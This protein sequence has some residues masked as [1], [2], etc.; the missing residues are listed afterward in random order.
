MENMEQHPEE[1]QKSPKPI[2]HDYDKHQNDPGPAPQAV[3]EDD[4]QGAGLAMKW[5]IPI[6][7]IVLLIVYWIMF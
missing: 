6:V 4:N 7:I 2:E 3:E 5:V 1:H